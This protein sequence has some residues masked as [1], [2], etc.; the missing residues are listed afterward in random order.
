LLGYGKWLESQGVVFDE[1]NQELQE[2]L[3]WNYTAKELMFWASQKWAPGSVITLSPFAQKL[4]FVND[5]AVVDNLFNPFYEYSILNASG[6][7]L[8]RGNVSVFREEDDFI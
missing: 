3:N 4:K 5:Y 2:I 1:Y 8:P 7:L 6:N